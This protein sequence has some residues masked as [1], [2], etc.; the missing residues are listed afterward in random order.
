MDRSQEDVGVGG[1]VRHPVVPHGRVPL[2]DEQAPLLHQPLDDDVLVVPLLPGL[3]PG[4]W[5]FS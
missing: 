4:T 1:V 2:L 5:Y 3:A